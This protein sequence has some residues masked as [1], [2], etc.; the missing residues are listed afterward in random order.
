VPQGITPSPQDFAMPQAEEL[1]AQILQ[2]LQQQNEPK[3]GFT[4]PPVPQCIYVNRQ[5]E[6]CLWFF[7]NHAEQTHEPI[8]SR[9][10]R[11]VVERVEVLEK[12]YKGKRNQ[13]LRVRV[14]ADHPYILESGLETVFAKGLLHKIASLEPEQLQRPLTL[15]VQE[16]EEAT[17]V[18]AQL[19]DTSGK[20]VV[21]P[22]SEQTNWGQVIDEAIA[23]LAIAHGEIPQSENA[24]LAPAEL[25]RA[26]K[27]KQ[28]K[29]KPQIYEPSGLVDRYRF[30][31]N[32]AVTWADVTAAND[33]IRAPEQWGEVSSLPGLEADLNRWSA[34]ARARITTETVGDPEDLSDLIAATTVQLSRL[35]W[36]TAQGREHL[37]ANYGC[38]GRSQLS[39]IQLTDFLEFLQN[40]P[41]PVPL[42]SAPF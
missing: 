41:D 24:E 28:A 15:A 21:A 5:Y 9:A 36:T 31:L 32:N 34:S 26:Q 35:Q 16:G 27:P 38:K 14:R 40:Q 10:L 17:V 19:F 42:A 20:L 1:L 25:A 39:P 22:Y 37:A 7:W 4:A 23:K 33:W 12:E 13:K 30:Y 18:F 11:C 6:D 2:V 8:R 3:L 29:A